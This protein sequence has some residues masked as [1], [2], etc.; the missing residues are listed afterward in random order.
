[1][2]WL[3][4]WSHTTGAQDL[5]KVAPIGTA[6]VAAFALC[7]AIASI[8]I[9]RAVAQR[10]AAIDFFLKTDMDEKMLEAHRKYNLALDEMARGPLTRDLHQAVKSYL[11]IHELMA[12]GVHNHVFD[13]R[14]CHE[15]WADELNRCHD[16][17]ELFIAA[18][19]Q[20]DGPTALAAQVQLRRE[21]RQIGPMTDWSWRRRQFKRIARRLIGY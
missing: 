6:A 14:T 9:Q 8:W 18:T 15:F 12:V 7:A 21:W 17:C 11:N 13:E 10:R 16:K 4:A 2:S 3:S 20:L 5:A 19:Q 1:M